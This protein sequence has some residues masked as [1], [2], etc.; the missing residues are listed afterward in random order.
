[1]LKTLLKA[2]GLIASLAWFSVASA[3]DIGGI[4]VTSALGHPLKAEISLSELGQTDKARITAKL[5]S[6]NDFKSAGL[7]YPYNLPKLSFEINTRA[8]GEAYIKLTSS[9][10][11]NDPFVSLLIELS[12]PSGKLLREY[13]FL[14]DPAGFAPEQPKMAEVK[15]VEP[16]VPVVE[17]APA[18]VPVPVVP[19]AETA[20]VE[21]VPAVAEVAA[22]PAQ[23]EGE[24][25]AAEPVPVMSDMAKAELA[26]AEAAKT[27][28]AMNGPAKV[29]PSEPVKV[30]PLAPT[31]E[32]AAATASIRVDK[33][34][35]LGKI[36][37]A[38]KPVDVSLERMLVAMYRANAKTFDGKNMNR[39]KAGKILRMPESVEI[40]KVTQAAAVKE[41]RAQVA[42]W[43]DYRQKLAATQSVS[44]EQ[45]PTQEAAGK[46]ST[47]VAEKAPV[48]KESAKEVLRLS[49]GEALGDK[50]V[51]GGAALSKQEKQ[52]A[53]ADD[54]AAKSKQTQ[55]DQKKIAKL[56]TINKDV[57]KLGKSVV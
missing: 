53:K 23:E 42:D 9:Q 30:E 16:M 7:D 44:A 43:Q 12:W 37:D 15:P 38:A 13:T 18:I 10:P 55:E 39:I 27:E 50:T 6:V 8:N 11:I 2:V 47:A 48:V 31:P 3:A 17:P 29:E 20:P 26:A 49:K 57:S 40:A 4:N 52:A 19:L 54:A 51:P 41:I 1:M 24:K 32:G 21:V 25:K 45:K 5:A 35:T 46:V 14:L 22:M 36:A 56:E 33:G 28:S 34:D